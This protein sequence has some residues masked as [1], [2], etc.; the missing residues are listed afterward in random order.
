MELKIIDLSGEKILN[1]VDLWY[2]IPNI[3]NIIN[4]PIR[5]IF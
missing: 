2:I 5:V 3:N 1:R 4:V